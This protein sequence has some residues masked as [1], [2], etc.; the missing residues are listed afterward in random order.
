MKEYDEM[1]TLPENEKDHP[2]V[3]APPPLIYLA[4]F[5]VGWGLERFFPTRAFLPVW[6]TV[7]AGLVCLSFGALLVGWAFR[8]FHRAGTNANPYRPAV[9]LVTD[10]PFRFTR[11]PMYVSL[12]SLYLGVTMLL[13][14]AWPLLLLPVVLTV[15]YYGVITREE[16]YLE[17]KFGRAY[18]DYMR[19]VPRWIG[20]NR[21]SSPPQTGL[22]DQE[23]RGD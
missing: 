14:A 3:I 6:I 19:Q 2:G 21:P 9:A 13:R 10:G 1:R 12:T 22:R 16:R 5:I 11:N 8:T 23:G 18:I 17:K 7:M 4:G 15:L 20:W